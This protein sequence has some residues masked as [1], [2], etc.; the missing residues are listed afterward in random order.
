MGARLRLGPQAFKLALM[1][2][3]PWA[4]GR[5]LCALPLS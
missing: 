1:G 5:R 4:S 3:K 2:L